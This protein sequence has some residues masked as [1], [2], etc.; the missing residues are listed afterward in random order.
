MFRVA[1]DGFRAAGD[2]CRLGFAVAR[3][4]ACHG[5]AARAL[6]LRRRCAGFVDDGPVTVMDPPWP[7]YLFV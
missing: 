6:Y 1:S 7:V 4:V 3:G 5:N 2:V